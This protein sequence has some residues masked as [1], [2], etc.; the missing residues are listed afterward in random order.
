M[1]PDRYRIPLETAHQI[2]AT[3]GITRPTR[4]YERWV[5]EDG[6]DL[7]DFD[8]VLFESPYIFVIDWR[9]YLHDE[10]ETIIRALARLDVQIRLDLDEEGESGFVVSPDGK[11]AR[12]AYRPIDG[13][14]FDHV[15]RSAKG[16]SRTH[17]VSG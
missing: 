15:P 6:F 17:R 16:R 3:F 4:A 5:K 9:C 13:P 14:D 8:E 1:D 11:R 12:V 7:K 2:L 10:L